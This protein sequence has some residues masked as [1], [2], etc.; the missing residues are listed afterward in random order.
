MSL[1]TADIE[2]LKDRGLPYSVSAEAGMI[3]VVMPGF[4]LPEGCNLTASDLLVRLTPGFPDVTPD[5]WWFDPPVMLKSGA[6]IQATEARETHLGRVW[7]RWS[8]HL[9]AGQWRSGIDRL[10]N[11]V[12]LIRAEVARCCAGVT[13]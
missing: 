13:A 3:C 10:E 12:A 7:Q 5:M 4:A 2:F 6:T 1:P 11:Y 9:Q 8:R